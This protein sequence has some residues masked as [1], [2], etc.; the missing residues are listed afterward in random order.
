MDEKEL[1][2]IEESAQD[3]AVACPDKV[4]D[5]CNGTPCYACLAKS[6]YDNHYRKIPDGAVVLTKE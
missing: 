5:G 4:D 1:R 3:I 2:E 6:L